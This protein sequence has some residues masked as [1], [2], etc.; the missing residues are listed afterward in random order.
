M[1]YFQ[2]ISPGPVRTEFFTA[3]ALDTQSAHFEEFLETLPM[4]EA[5]DVADAA[6][7]ILSTPP[8]VQVRSRFYIINF[9]LISNDI[10]QVQ[11]IM[12]RPLGEP[13]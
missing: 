12:L 3:N 9:V 2:S 10:S 4:L 8:H 1:T 7:Y 13:V 6:I 5:D 11:D